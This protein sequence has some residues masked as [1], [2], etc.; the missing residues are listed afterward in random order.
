[1][2]ISNLT[3]TVHTNL[4]THLYSSSMRDAHKLYYRQIILN[5][6]FTLACDLI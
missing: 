5:H 4:L 6:N 3:R 1:M 2:V